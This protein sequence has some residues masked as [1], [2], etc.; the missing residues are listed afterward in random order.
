M[1][2]KTIA[3]IS[4]V[5]ILSFI[6]KMMFIVNNP[7]DPIQD[8]ET[9]YNVAVNLA[10]GEGFTLDGYEWGFQSYGYPLILSVFFRI[11]GT[12]SIFAAKVFNVI[13]ST[14]TLIIFYFIFDK[15]FEKKLVTNLC[16]ILMA[17]LPNNI[18]YNAVLGTEVLSVFLLSIIICMNFY[19]KPENKVN[20]VIQGILIGIL[21]LVKPFFMA[22]PVVLIFV[23]LMK[24]KNIKYI[25]KYS[26]PLI[27]GFMCIM[28]PSII[29]NYNQFGE[30]IP[31]SYNGG[32][33]LYINNN[34][35]NTRGTWMN[36]YKVRSTESFKNRLMAV[37]Y[38]ITPDAAIE[39][40]ENL[41]N[42]KAS[43]VYKE[44][45]VSW[46]LSHP[47]EFITLGFLRLS[48]VYFTGAWDI[49]NWG[50]EAATLNRFTA[51]GNRLFKVERS[52]VGCIL[53]S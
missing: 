24:E 33:T 38:D 29:K 51:Q 4:V 35:E 49:Q 12:T 7:L 18:I 15:M 21:S 10:S 22:Y 34:S 40:Q 26:I 2:K 9:L 6:I 44:E 53:E 32:F 41:R 14:L 27:I 46:I 37:G 13:L 5:V 45:A 23:Y 3:F 25:V 52:K 16:F 31:I 50:F 8:F 43:K 20:L 39:K 11:V 1:N 42:A 47:A 30:F 48:N 36:G 19:L 17:I 28:I